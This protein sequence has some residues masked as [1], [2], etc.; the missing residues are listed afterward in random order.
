M[1]KYTHTHTYTYTTDS[2]TSSLVLLHPA[3]HYSIH[4]YNVPAFF[5]LVIVT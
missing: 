5:P 2:K 1:Y 3:F 4:M